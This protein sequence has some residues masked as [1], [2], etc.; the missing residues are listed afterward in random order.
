MTWDFPGPIYRARATTLQDPTRPPGDSNPATSPGTRIKIK[1]FNYLPAQTYAE[2]QECIP[3]TYNACSGTS[4]CVP[5]RA[6]PPPDSKPQTPCTQQS[7]CA[8]VP[9]SVCLPL[10]CTPSTPTAPDTIC[11]PLGTTCENRPVIQEHPNCF[12]GTSVT[13]F[14]LHG[15]HVS[16][17][18]HNDFVLLNLFPYGSQGVPTGRPVPDACDASGGDPFYAVGCYQVDVNPLPW[19]QAPGTHWYHPHKHGGTTAQR[20]ERHGRGAGVGGAFETV[21][22][23]YGNH[24]SIGLWR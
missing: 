24:L 13:N 6:T 10:R 3:A 20:Q 16:P 4:Y 23:V 22:L 18:P 2:A 21:E 14:H 1:L 17:Q 19:N 12:H 7:D 11:P 8:G 9:N 15:T 5:A